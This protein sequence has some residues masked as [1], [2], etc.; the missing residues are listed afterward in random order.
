MIAR[1][2]LGFSDKTFGL[3]LQKLERFEER[4]VRGALQRIGIL[5][6]K[7]HE[8]FHGSLIFP[9]VD[10]YGCYTGAYGRRVS[11]DP[12][13]GSVEHVHWV[14]SKTTFFNEQAI[15]RDKH[16]VV[17]K[18]PLEALSWY[19]AG[20]RNAVATM[21]IHAFDHRHVAVLK[22]KGVECLDIAFNN[23]DEG[24]AAAEKI[25]KQLHHTGIQSRRVVFPEGH[26]SNSLLTSVDKPKSYFQSLIHQATPYT[27]LRVIH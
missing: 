8:F 23:D 10:M 26:D 15:R 17:C 25:V 1:F 21:G 18:S 5:K 11:E 2:N 6:P 7:G 16:I 12:K 24:V 3:R 4:L 22:S 27:S 13:W 19:Q 9:F 14:T 20:F